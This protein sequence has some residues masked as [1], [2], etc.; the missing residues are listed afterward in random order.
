MNL[1][2]VL[3]AESEA[4]SLVCRASLFKMGISFSLCAFPDRFLVFLYGGFSFELNNNVLSLL[5]ILINWLLKLSFCSNSSFW[6]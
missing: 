3:L 2:E 4:N 1:P 5:I 6:S